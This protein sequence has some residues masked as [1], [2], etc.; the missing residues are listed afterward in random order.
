MTR[1]TEDQLDFDVGNLIDTINKLLQNDLDESLISKL[2][3]LREDLE[4][5]LT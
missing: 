4:F 3:N 1:T 5:N 2:E